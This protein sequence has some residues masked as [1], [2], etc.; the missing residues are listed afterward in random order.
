MSDLKDLLNYGISE[1]VMPGYKVAKTKHYITKSYSFSPSKDSSRSKIDK[2]QSKYPDPAKYGETLEQTF[3]KHWRKAS[4]QFPKS[5][6]KS[7]LD[8]II[9]SSKKIP[10]PGSYN[11]LPKNVIPSRKSPL[12]K[13]E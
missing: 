7:Y 6:K 5:P 2:E 12:G 9:K 4:G 3:K 11:K 1:W 8:E 10:G 13:F